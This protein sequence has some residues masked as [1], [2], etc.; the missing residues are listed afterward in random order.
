MRPGFLLASHPWSHQHRTTAPP[1]AL[2]PKGA[3]PVS[4]VVN[5]HP[6]RTRV[7]SGFWMPPRPLLHAA[8]LSPLPK[9]F[10][11]GLADPNWRAA[12]GEEHRA[13][14]QNSTWGLV[15]RSPRANVVSGKWIFK[16]KFQTDGSL[17]RYKARW[18]LRGFSQHPGVDFDEISAK[19]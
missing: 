17:E 13:L 12:M 3:A 4:P 7:K 19:L 14:L 8:P 10:R 9:T 2:L 15:P 11:G 6:M 1:A 5:A 16:H 18:V